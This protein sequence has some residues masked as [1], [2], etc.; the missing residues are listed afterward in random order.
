[1]NKTINPPCL[2]KERRKWKLF[3][4]ARVVVMWTVP[5]QPGCWNA[6]IDQ[7]HLTSPLYMRLLLVKR[8]GG[9]RKTRVRKLMTNRKLSLLV[10][11]CQ[12]LVGTTQRASPLKKQ[13]GELV[14]V[15]RKRLLWIQR[16]NQLVS[17]QTSQ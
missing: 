6:L 7:F 16:D 12:L 2:M 4:D 8:Q 17:F 5:E 15:Q 3:W 14:S 9:E 1:M 13:L 10:D 11:L